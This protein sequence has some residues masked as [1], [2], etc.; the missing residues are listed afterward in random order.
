MVIMM[1][2]IFVIF[3]FLMIRPQQKRQKELKQQ[4]ESISKGDKFITAGGIYATVVSIKENVVTA[5]IADDVKVEIAKSAI[6]AVLPK[7][8]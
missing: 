1:A 7:D 3:Y 2:G 8:A 4:I 5:K 6:S